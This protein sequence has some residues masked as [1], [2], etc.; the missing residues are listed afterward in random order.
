[1]HQARRISLLF[2]AVFRCPFLKLKLPRIISIAVPFDY[3]S[4]HWHFSRQIRNILILINAHF[5]VYALLIAH[6]R[7]IFLKALLVYRGEHGLVLRFLGKAFAFDRQIPRRHT[8]HVITFSQIFTLF[9]WLV[10]QTILIHRITVIHVYFQRTF[11]NILYILR[12]ST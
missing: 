5:V 3:S 1:M 4:R 8:T 11:L 6:Y 7:G 12:K 2:A 10:A 9:S